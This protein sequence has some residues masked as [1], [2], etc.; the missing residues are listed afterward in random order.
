[1]KYITQCPIVIA[2]PTLHVINKTHV[3][4]D[5]NKSFIQFKTINILFTYF[6]TVGALLPSYA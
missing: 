3:W 2:F 6:G 4:Y 5:K 1:M